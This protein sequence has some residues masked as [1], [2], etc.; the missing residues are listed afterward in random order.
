MGGLYLA[1]VSPS[2]GSYLVGVSSLL[3]MLA[4]LGCGGY[5]LR[6]WLAPS[7]GGALARL[8]ELVLALALLILT[9]EVIGSSAE[10]RVAW[11]VPACIIVGLSFAALGRWRAPPEAEPAEA[12]PVPNPALGVAIAVAAVAVGEWSFP[13]LLHLGRG[14]FSGD[15]T[16]YHLPFATRFAQ[17]HSTWNL[18]FTDPLAL[19]AWFYP[20]NSELLGAVGILLFHSDW[21]SPLINIAWLAL[22]LLAA[23]CVGRPFGV[24]PATLVASAIALDS[25]ILL[26]TQAGE[27]RNDAMAISLL[28]VFAA[29]LSNGYRDGGWGVLVPAGLAG[30][31]AASVKLTMLAPVGGATLIALTAIALRRRGARLGGAAAL[32]GA[33]LLAGGYWYLRNLAHSGNPVPQVHRIGPIALPHPRQM[34]LY[35][36]PPRSVAHYLFDARVI[37]VWFLPKLQ[38]ALGLLYPLILVVALL[39]AIWAIVGM[40]DPILAALGLAA[41]LTSTVYLFTPLTAAGPLGQP[42][43]FLT[44]TRYLLPGVALALALL[45]LAGP[46]RRGRWRA[47]ATLCCLVAVFAVTVASTGAWESRFLAGAL[48]ICASLV[49]IPAVAGWLRGMNKL[50]RPLAI[51]LALSMLVPAI[52]LGHAQELRYARGHYTLPTHRAEQPEG[53]VKIFAWAR[54]LHD[55]RIALAGAGELFFDQAFFAGADSSNWVQYV[56]QPGP[57][58]AYRVA[59]SCGDFRRLVNRGHYNYLVI[60][61]FGDNSPQRRRFPLREWVR[62]SPG[63]TLIRSEGAYPQTVFAFRVRGN[64]HPGSCRRQ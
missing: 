36:R 31:L 4:A 49:V 63:L 10:L 47:M 14:I 15:S 33:E 37:R 40:R 8:A 39:A 28:L 56:G 17:S 61:E 2:L 55:R 43:G 13:S 35:P 6:R 21:L 5:W 45:P 20:A 9:L 42:H 57:H 12:P 25:G 46:L 48:F 50:G 30:G 18:L 26:L 34:N 59:P 58:G 22:G 1:I 38:E 29:L 54:R 41:L 16:W 44:N 3:A 19:T 62:G 53:P 11:M 52:A 60:T 64:L 23:Y 27:A 24:G 7:Y 51:T 32:L